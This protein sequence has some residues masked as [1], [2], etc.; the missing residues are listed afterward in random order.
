MLGNQSDHGYKIN[1]TNDMLNNEEILTVKTGQILFMSSFLP[2]KTYVNPNTSKS[3]ISL[4]RRVI[5]DFGCK[6]WGKR[7]C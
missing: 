1:I 3:K 2:H 5:D 4:S 6:A 7:L